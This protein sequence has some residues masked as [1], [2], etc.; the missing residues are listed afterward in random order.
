MG[1]CLLYHYHLSSISYMAD[2]TGGRRSSKLGDRESGSG[3][4]R[5]E[6]G[7]IGETGRGVAVAP[8]LWRPS[9]ESSLSLYSALPET[10]AR[11]GDGL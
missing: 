1:S 5:E 7:L 4:E 3:E 11:G 8:F 9:L 10:T 2:G 6:G